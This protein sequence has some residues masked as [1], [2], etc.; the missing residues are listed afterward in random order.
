M[1]RAIG[2]ALLSV[3][4]TACTHTDTLASKPVAAI[5]QLQGHV[6]VKFDIDT[7]GRIQNAQ[8]IES[9]TTPERENYIL[10]GMKAWRYMKGKPATGRIV[11]VRF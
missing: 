1:I 3:V 2:I 6:R 4:L 8:V 11:N 10:N 9:T 5:G 7:D